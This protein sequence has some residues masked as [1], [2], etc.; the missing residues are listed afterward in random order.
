MVKTSAVVIPFPARPGGDMARL[1]RSLAGL[2]QAL[3][4]QST[5]IAAWRAALSE[6]HTSVATLGTS[7][8]SY[9]GALSK[10]GKTA[11]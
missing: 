3:Q 9:S 4:D 1:A 2:R 11:K 10:V 8:Q 5:A 7:L 6:L